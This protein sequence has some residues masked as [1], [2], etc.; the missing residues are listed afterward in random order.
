[1]RALSLARAGGLRISPATLRA[2]GVYRGSLGEVS[3][4]TTYCS[5]VP[6]LFL[7]GQRICEKKAHSCDSKAC[8]KT[9][10]QWGFSSPQ[11]C[12][13]SSCAVCSSPACC[14]LWGESGTRVDLL[15][16]FLRDRGSQICRAGGLGHDNMLT[17]GSGVSAK[18]DLMWASLSR[19]ASLPVWNRATFKP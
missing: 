14:K 6:L 18:E 13:A 10:L 3:I 2:C 9:S 4:G 11:L 8:C 17:L 15:T 7:E 5:E 16:Y 19:V 1:M 12:Q